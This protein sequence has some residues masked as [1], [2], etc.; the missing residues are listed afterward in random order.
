MKAAY[1]SRIKEPWLEATEARIA[2]CA[3]FFDGEGGINFPGGSVML[4]ATQRVCEPLE[5]FQGVFGGSIYEPSGREEGH[6]TDARGTKYP[7]GDVTW[8]WSKTGNK[9]CLSV[10]EVLLPYLIVKRAQAE[11]TIEFIRIAPGSSS[12]AGSSP[13]ASPEIRARRTAIIVEV[14]ALMRPWLRG[15]DA[16]GSPDTP[17]E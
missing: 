16:N 6:T 1:Q 13:G 3:G 9:N 2:Y 14:K 10:L 8:K 15:G 12:S 4:R 5:L 11:L 7:K 17:S